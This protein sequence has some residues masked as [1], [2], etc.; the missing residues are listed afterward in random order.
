MPGA[1]HRDRAWH[2]HAR[3][4]I[5]AAPGAGSHVVAA[6]AP[7]PGPQNWAGAPSAVLDDDGSIVVG[8]RVRH[9]GELRDKVVIARSED[10]ERLETVAVLTRGQFAR[11]CSSAALGRTETGAWRAWVGV[12]TPGTKHWRIEMLEAP[13]AEGLADAHPRSRSPAIR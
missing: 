11:R 1:A 3:H 10:G 8:Y 13:T 5:A 2:E 12:A 6:A 9:A 7:G 4:H